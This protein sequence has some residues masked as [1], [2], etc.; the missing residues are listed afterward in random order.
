M[1]DR[2]SKKA[3]NTKVW[4]ETTR[5]CAMASSPILDLEPKVQGLGVHNYHYTAARLHVVVLQ[6]R[7]YG[8]VTQASL[9]GVRR[10]YCDSCGKG[11]S[12]QLTAALKNAVKKSKVAWTL[13]VEGGVLGRTNPTTVD[14]EGDRLQHDGYQCSIWALQFEHWFLQFLES[15]KECFVQWLQRVEEG[16]SSRLSRRNAFIA[17]RRQ[18]FRMALAAGDVFDDSGRFQ[19]GD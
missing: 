10:Y 15:G 6:S 16:R 9:I 11:A 3:Y 8:A 17:A 13:Q 2:G 12:R 19:G 4:T 14:P 18:V 1:S 7:M 5:R